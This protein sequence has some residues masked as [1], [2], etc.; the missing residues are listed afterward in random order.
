MAL[1][2]FVGWSDSTNFVQT[3]VSQQF[4]FNA[5]VQGLQR[6]NAAHFGDTAAPLTGQNL[7][8]STGMLKH[9]LDALIDSDVLCLQMLN[10]VDAGD[11]LAFPP[12]GDANVVVSV[13]MF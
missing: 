4:E 12:S 13:E 10:P 6:M 11:S 1:G 5:L 3:E 7:E 2:I 9:L 8:M